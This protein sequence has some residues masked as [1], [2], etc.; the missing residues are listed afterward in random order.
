MEEFPNALS[1]GA[2]YGKARVLAGECVQ[3]DGLGP[4]VHEFVSCFLLQCREGGRGES[5]WQA[6]CLFGQTVN[7]FI[8]TNAHMSWALVEMNGEL[9]VG[10]KEELDAFVPVWE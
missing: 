5:R 1:G 9:A 8:A 4:L 10:F 2:I 3:V 6:G 7:L